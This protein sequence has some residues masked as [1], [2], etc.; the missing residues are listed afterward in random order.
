MKRTITTLAAALLCATIVDAQ[1]FNGLGMNLGNLS[2]LSN[3]ETRSI[4]PEN[5][6]GGKGQAATAKPT[7][8]PVRN[9]NNA[10]ARS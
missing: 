6:S 9:V 4:C 1:E 10:S 7:D 3:A 5:F 8:P 2:L